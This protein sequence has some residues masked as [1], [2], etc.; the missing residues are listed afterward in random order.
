MLHPRSFKKSRSPVKRKRTKMMM[1]RATKI[2]RKTKRK[3]MVPKV[4]TVMLN[5]AVTVMS[6]KTRKKLKRI[7]TVLKATKKSKKKRNLLHPSA[8]STCICP[9]ARMTTRLELLVKSMLR[10]SKL[11]TWFLNSKKRT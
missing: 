11:K 6:K 7:K 3:K 5:K 1:L 10:S 9:S 2:T 4:S 8:R